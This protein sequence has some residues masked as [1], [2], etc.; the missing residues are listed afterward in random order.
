MT[1]PTAQPER[2][3]IRV[4][5]HLDPRWAEWFD[6]LTLT[7]T[8]AGETVLA[9]PVADQAALHGLLVRIRDLNL[10]LVSVTRVEPEQ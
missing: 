6:D 8:E 3:V 2:Y 4:K 9:G 1:Q 7:H 5:G 10:M